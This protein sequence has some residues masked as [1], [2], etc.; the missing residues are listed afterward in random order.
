MQTWKEHFKNLL[1]NSP[2]I[3]DR[4][5]TKI[6]NKQ[7]EIKLGQFI[8]KELN[9][10]LTKIKNRKAAGFKGCILPFPKKGDYK[11]ITLTFIAA[12]VY[13]TLFC[14]SMASNQKLR[15]L[16]QKI[17]TVYGEIDPQHH[18]F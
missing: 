17:K 18:R 16:F 8:Q 6:I 10:V 1:R 11:D 7:L 13:H 5:I 15:K 3:I 12:K 9:A 2:K 4:T 14:F